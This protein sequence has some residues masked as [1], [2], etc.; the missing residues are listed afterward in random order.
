MVFREHRAAR[1]YVDS[2]PFN[3]TATYVNGSNPSS[4]EWF[5]DCGSGPAGQGSHAASGQPS[6]TVTLSID[7]ASASVGVCTYHVEVTDDVNT[8]S[9]SPATV[10]IANH[11][12][13]GVLADQTVYPVGAP[14]TVSVITTGGLGNLTY[15]WYKDG[16]PLSDTSNIIGTGTSTLSFVSFTE[17]DNGDYYLQVNDEV[18]PPVISD[19]ATF[20]TD[21]TPP[22]PIATGA[23]IASLAAVVMCLG[24]GKLRRKK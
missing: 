7:P 13:I 17:L 2:V 5:A 4:Y 24:V 8:Y 15:Q 22:V 3:L 19:T 20:Q 14:L 12:T 21:S 10:Q 18:D 16:S 11:V 9:S 6:D 1:A 23:G